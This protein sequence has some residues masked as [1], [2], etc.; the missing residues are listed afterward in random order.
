MKIKP[1][2]VLV[3]D[4]CK[5]YED[6]RDLGVYAYNGKLDIRPPYQREWVYGDKERNLVIDTVRKGFP[7][8][9]MYWAD[10]GNDKYEVIDG[11]QR[12]ISICEYVE[13]NFSIKW[14]EEI[15]TYHNLKEKKIKI[16]NYPLQVYICSGTEDEK[17]DWFRT[18]NIAGKT[19][20]PQELRNATYRGPW[21]SHAKTI[22]SKQNCAAYG[23]ANKYINAKLNRQGYLEKAIRWISNDKLNN[24][25]EQFDENIKNY[26]ADHQHDQN[27]DELWKFFQK[28]INWVEENFEI[29]NKEVSYIDWGIYYKLFKDKKFRSEE[30]KKKVQK[31]IMD[32]DV[33]KKSGIYPYILT[34]E[35]KYLN[36]RAFSQAIKLKV[37]TKQKG[38]CNKCKKE[39]KIEDMEAD[40]IK[41]WVN[42][43]RTTEDN[44]QMLCV[45]DHK[46]M[47]NK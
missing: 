12:I 29:H 23:L 37:F 40:H 1:T 27:A 47:K 34:G 2:T 15:L 11:Q 41:S 36:I 17:L 13:G 35:E 16:D 25:I 46:L 6:K 44:C 19:L 42:G 9:S 24:S 14:D 32:D 4:L 20:E 21:V 30:I 7:L 43:G 8:N 26:M 38:K 45:K 28:V 31:Y 22:F 10:I 18:I 33:E 39:F 3:K 5:N